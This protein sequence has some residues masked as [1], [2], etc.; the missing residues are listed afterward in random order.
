[1]KKGTARITV[2]RPLVLKPIK[3]PDIVTY[4]K[5]RDYIFN[6]GNPDSPPLTLSFCE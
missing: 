2:S 5:I 1:M 4:Y 6:P 3:P